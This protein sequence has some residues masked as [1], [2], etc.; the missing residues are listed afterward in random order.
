M[1]TLPLETCISRLYEPFAPR[2]TFLALILILMANRLKCGCAR[3]RG[4]A[5]GNG[6][7]R[8]AKVS[9]NDMPLSSRGVGFK[10]TCNTFCVF[11]RNLVVLLR[12]RQSKSVALTIKIYVMQP[13]ANF[14]V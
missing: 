8:L 9:R 3:V 6:E 5:G 10:S 13:S 7:G 4:V 2:S 14:S 1:V 11:V 12:S